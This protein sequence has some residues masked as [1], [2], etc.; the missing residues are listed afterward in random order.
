MKTKFFIY[1]AL[2]LSMSSVAQPVLKDAAGKSYFNYTV[3]AGQSLFA[4]AKANKVTVKELTD[5]NKLGANAGIKVGQVLRI[6]TTKPA[7]AAAPAPK[8]TPL[9]TKP[10]PAEIVTPN[11]TNS[12]ATG[13]PIYYTV[14][15]KEWLYG[16]AKKHN[17]TVAN[18][19]KWNNLPSDNIEAGQ[20]II[21]GYANGAEPTNPP[22][23]QVPEEMENVV[24]EPPTPAPTK[25]P[26]APTP[27]VNEVKPIANVTEEG[28]FK[29]EF[30]RKE[31]MGNVKN[32]KN[33]K[34]AFFTINNGLQR[35]YYAL[36]DGANL[37]D[38]L[39]VTNKANG[40]IV[41]VKV[42]GDL[43]EL[44]QN[45]GLTVRLSET[46]AA[47]LGVTGESFDVTVSY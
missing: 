30:G 39:K 8:P 32:S 28:Y 43:Q 20:K 25:Q 37:G 14:P 6:P 24:V 21:V 1:S 18:I 3:T 15:P 44:K 47:A 23:A 34:A 7:S 40:K 36:V 4:I 11:N 33:G 45:Q 31:S 35:K 17:T 27:A 12:S 5:Y 13:T 46:T 38:V 10:K 42:L 41:Y 29:T 2:L 26:A 19:K 9:V 16:I 22:A